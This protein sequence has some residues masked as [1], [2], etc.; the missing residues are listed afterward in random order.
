MNC[1][2]CHSP[3]AETFC[4]LGSSPPSNSFLNEEQCTSPEIY[5]PLVIRVCQNC[6]LVQTLDFTRREELFTHDYSYF[7]SYSATFLEHSRSYVEQMR[8]EFNLNKGN[9]VVEIASNDG[10][11]LQFV[12][13]AGI[14]CLGVEPT[15]STAAVSKE[16]GIPTLC[17]FFG[18]T[19]ATKILEDSQ[20]ANLMIAN[21]VLAHVPDINGFIQGFAV[22]LAEDGVATFE[23]PHLLKLIEQTAFDTIYHEHYSYLSLTAVVEIFDKNGLEVFRVEEIS[24]HGGSL[25]VFAQKSEHKAK[26]IDK[27][28]G[29]LLAQEEETGVR[30][31]EFYSNFQEKVVKRKNSLLSFLLENQ[32]NKIIG[33]GAAAKASTFL[34]YAGVRKDLI[35][36]VVDKNPNKSGKYLPGCKIPI[37]EESEIISLE[38]DYIVIF[39]WN[40]KEE[41]MLQLDYTRNWGAKFV[42]F[43]PETQTFD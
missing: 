22:L 14:P 35:P 1:R 9:F 18:V 33:Y 19:T 13:D 27:S 24:T 20:P 5:Y 34:N 17:E 11:L 21:N 25:R 15:E 29:K 10:Y 30:T 32:N 41:I 26:G 31:L 37:V 43:I 23:F 40:I 2:H 7:S 36:F 3:L 42:T 12:K 6:W 4:D 8:N 39:P 28:V 38:P 16:K